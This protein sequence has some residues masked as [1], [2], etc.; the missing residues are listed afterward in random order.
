MAKSDLF[1]GI[2]YDL[3][4]KVLSFEELKVQALDRDDDAD[5]KEILS[6]FS[7]DLQSAKNDNQII[8]QFSNNFY[9][10]LLDSIEEGTYFYKLISLKRDTLALRDIAR[11]SYNNHQKLLHESSDIFMQNPYLVDE[12]IKFEKDSLE[13]VSVRD[14]EE[15]ID[16]IYYTSLLTKS[17]KTDSYISEY[18]DLIIRNKNIETYQRIG[19]NYEDVDVKRYLFNTQGDYA[20]EGTVM[21]LQSYI[22]DLNTSKNSKNLTIILKE[23]E[24]EYVNQSMTNS[25]HSLAVLQLITRVDLMLYNLGLLN[26]LD[27]NEIGDYL[28]DYDTL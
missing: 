12:W 1:I 2:I 17:A 3:N 8:K 18:T 16:K 13:A 4:A 23:L 11:H 6:V 14:F 10:H 20:D 7:Y 21:E 9:S 28:I 26:I 22:N 15:L 19:E 24:A 27:K 25:S 5:L